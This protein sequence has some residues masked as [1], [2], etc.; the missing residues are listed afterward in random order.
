VKHPPITQPSIPLD[1]AK[2][3][4]IANRV[5]HNNER[6]P[7]KA[8]RLRPFTESELLIVGRYAR[9]V[10]VH[11]MGL[12]S[13]CVKAWEELDERS[14]PAVEREMKKLVKYGWG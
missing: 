2:I 6:R 12:R 13:A 7:K 11:V 9:D 14:L 10:R 5:H 8:H 1:K 4:A 3:A